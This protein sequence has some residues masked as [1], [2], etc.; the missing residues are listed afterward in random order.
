[1]TDERFFEDTV[2]RKPSIL[3]KILAVVLFILATT[4]LLGG[5]I[6]L[7]TG[8]GALFIMASIVLYVMIY[9]LLRSMSLE[10]DYNFTGGYF[11]IA[12]VIGK[13]KRKT[14]FNI[15]FKEDTD[16]L[17]P[18]TSP[19]LKEYEKLKIRTYDCTGS[20]P[21]AVV[22]C[23]VGKD[24]SNRGEQFRA[25]FEPDMEMLRAMHRVKPREVIITDD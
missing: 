9:F 3:Q 23:I 10:F 1:M 21:G 18:L 13:V 17:A 16:I 14:L 12:R 4:F 7:V 25:Y 20:T 15:N 24:S 2:T 5:V 22:Y 11:D 19:A 6:T 8:A